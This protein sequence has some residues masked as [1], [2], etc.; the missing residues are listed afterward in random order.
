MEDY[1]EGFV[2][3]DVAKAKHA[4]AI[5]ESAARAKFDL[6]ARSRTRR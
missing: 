1:S 4:V 2:G 6:S 3:F 5:A